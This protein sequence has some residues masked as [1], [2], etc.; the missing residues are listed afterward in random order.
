MARA[1]RRTGDLSTGL[2]ATTRNSSS[3]S[4]LL[5]TGLFQGFDL[6]L[7]HLQH[8]KAAEL[9]AAYSTLAALH[10]HDYP[11]AWTNLN[12]SVDLV[13][14]YQA[15]PF[16][17]SHLVKVAMANYALS[18]TWEALPCDEW[19]DEQLSHLQ[20]SWQN[21]DLFGPTEAAF[22]MERAIAN[23]TFSRARKSYAA[24]AAILG[25]PTS[26]PIDSLEDWRKAQFAY[27]TWKL[28]WSYDEERY[29]MQ[30]VQAALECCRAAKSNGIFVPA[31]NEY[32]DKLG[33]L[34]KQ[35][36]QVR[37]RFGLRLSGNYKST[38]L[39]FANAENARRMV[40]TAIALKRYHLRNGKYPSDLNA[41]IPEYLEKVPID[42][43]DGKPLRYQSKPDGV[44]LLYSVG[45]D[46][47]DNSGDATPTESTATKYKNWLKGRDA[48]WP[49]PATPDEIKAYQTNS[50]SKT[51]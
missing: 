39:K 17:V 2:V 36:A 46:G 50:A 6:P 5:Q 7:P 41:L 22:S 25:I 20:V 51:K 18:I 43:M 15:E 32:S 4:A 13:Q 19:S 16:I 9:L 34:N 31:F 1:H 42:L 3:S 12:S 11:E 44:F 47:E 48:V 26:G 21:M 24:W 35:S 27:W 45:E 28:S 30:I 40:V 8:L 23:D 33:D 14:H 29:N 49:L 38:L 10:Q 37:S